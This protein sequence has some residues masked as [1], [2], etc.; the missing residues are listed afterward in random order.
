MSKFA[1]GAALQ[2]LHQIGLILSCVIAIWH[3]PRGMDLS[4][5]LLDKAVNNFLAN[6]PSD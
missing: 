4:T 5:A 2:R 3:S 1:K 6:N